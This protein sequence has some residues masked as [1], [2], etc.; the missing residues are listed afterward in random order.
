VLQALMES[1]A[2]RE[3]RV[4][5]VRLEQREQ[6]E[7]LAQQEQQGLREL[8]GLTVLQERRVCPGS[9]GRQAPPE[10]RAVMVLL[11]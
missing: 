11:A 4:C 6:L 9:T 1:L 7:F 10:L 8:L 5:P 3:R 2:R